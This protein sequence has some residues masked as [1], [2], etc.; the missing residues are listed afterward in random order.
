MEYKNIDLDLDIDF[1]IILEK[2]YTIYL[3][4]DHICHKSE[5]SD[6]ILSFH[7]KWGEDFLYFKY[8]GYQFLAISAKG[9]S[10]AVN[11]V[12]RIRRAG[13]RAL[14]FIGTCGSTDEGISDGTFIIPYSAVRDEGASYGYFDK[15]VPAIA[16][17][18]FS[19]QLKQEIGIL[20][21]N[22]LM[23]VAYTTDKR[24]KE[25]PEL[26]RM[27]RKSMNLHCIDMETSAVLLVANSYTIKAATIRVVTDCAVKETDGILKGIF[28]V[29]KHHDFLSFVNPKLI[30]AFT[31]AVESCVKHYDGYCHAKN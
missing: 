22:V 12:E 11:A 2:N 25:D 6:V 7:P 8:H 28:D 5:Y 10:V 3:V 31:A 21:D 17:I 9:A 20:S 13:G 14:I 1:G 16:N 15:K 19:I 26:L 18:D 23:G 30:Q 4:Y 27:L 29:E 24:Y